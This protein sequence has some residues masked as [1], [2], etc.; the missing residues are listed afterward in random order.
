MTSFV[1][2]VIRLDVENRPISLIEKLCTLPNKSLLNVAPKPLA[3]RDDISATATENAKLAKANA[4]ILAP[5]IH[6]SFIALP[7]V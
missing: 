7:G 5:A 1:D 2:L 6:T 4:S 3:I